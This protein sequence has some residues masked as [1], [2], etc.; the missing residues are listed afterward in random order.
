M[1]RAKILKLKKLNVAHIFKYVCNLKIMYTFWYSFQPLNQANQH[2]NHDFFQVFENFLTW[3]T[4]R[5]LKVFGMKI[6][7]DYQ[8]LTTFFNNFTE[9]NL[10]SCLDHWNHYRYEN[11]HPDVSSF[12]ILMYHLNKQSASPYG[13]MHIFGLVVR[14][15]GS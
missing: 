6:P 14:L 8:K 15:T 7:V 4:N 12:C 9:F 5:S 11:L 3:K 1:N 10:L 2:L 13:L